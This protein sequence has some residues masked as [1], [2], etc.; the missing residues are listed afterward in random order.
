MINTLSAYIK[1]PIVII[2]L[3]KTNW[4]NDPYSL[5]S[6]TYAAVGNSAKDFQTL[7]NVVRY[8]SNNIWLIGEHTNPTD[9]SYTHGAYDSGYT[10]A[11]AALS[12]GP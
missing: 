1:Q 8:N 10:A 4:S 9:Y 6:Y 11:T 3:M 5:G 12:K 2:N 7:A